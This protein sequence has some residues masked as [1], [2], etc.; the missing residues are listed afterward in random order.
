MTTGATPRLADFLDDAVAPPDVLWHYT[1]AAGLKGIVETET[2]W[3]TDA[4]FSNDTAEIS[5]GFDVWDAA[6]DGYVYSGKK[7]TTGVR[8][9]AMRKATHEFLK[10]FV[11]TDLRPFLVCFCGDGDVLSQWRA[12]GGSDTAGGYA[13]GFAPPDSDVRLRLSRVVYDV[14]AQQRACA[15]LVD[16]LIRASDR[17]TR[18]ITAQRNLIGATL[19]SALDAAT[20]LKNPAFAEEQEWRLVHLHGRGGDALAVRHRLSRGLLVPYVEIEMPR[21][22]AVNCGPSPGPSRKQAGVR[23]LLDAHGYHDVT[24]QGSLA[25]LRV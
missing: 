6:L 19:W 7:V 13:L 20:M 8:V 18:D 16:A 15:A 21:L 2:F 3:A 9:E 22:V 23:S 10:P 11:V 17:N 24:V 4:T 14:E 25:P 1:D 12:Y 5:H